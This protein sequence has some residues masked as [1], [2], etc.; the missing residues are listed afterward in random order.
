MSVPGLAGFFDNSRVSRQNNSMRPKKKTF[1]LFKP[2][3]RTRSRR[4]RS[5]RTRTRRT[6]TRKTGRRRKREAEDVTLNKKMG[7]IGL[8]FIIFFNLTKLVPNFLKRNLSCEK[9][10]DFV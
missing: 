1:M 3:R 5:S 10:D 6:R 4:T 7:K 8:F 9:I 2:E